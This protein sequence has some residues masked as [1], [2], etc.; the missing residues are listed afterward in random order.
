MVRKSIKG[1][2][3]PY[4]AW[5]RTL[6]KWLG[7]MDLDAVEYNGQVTLSVYLEYNDNDK[8]VRACIEVI[9]INAES[10][11]E[12]PCTPDKFPSKYPIGDSEHGH[13]LEVLNSFSSKTD[14]PVFVVWVCWDLIERRDDGTIER[15]EPKAYFVKELPDNGETEMTPQKYETFLKRVRGLNTG[16]DFPFASV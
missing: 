11:G 4:S 5:H 6:P 3:E 1:D 2:S 8:D 13:K 9:N 14:V 10:G 16:S 7:L 15:A 12:L